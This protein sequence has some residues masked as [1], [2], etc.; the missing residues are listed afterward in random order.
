MLNSVLVSAAFNGNLQMENVMEEKG[1]TFKNSA[2]SKVG[3]A[4]AAIEISLTFGRDQNG[5]SF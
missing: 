2:N 4:S 1:F 3:N 5:D